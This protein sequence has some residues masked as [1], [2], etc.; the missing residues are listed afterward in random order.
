LRLCLIS[1]QVPSTSSATLPRAKKTKAGK[2]SQ[3]VGLSMI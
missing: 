3:M 1:S 2:I